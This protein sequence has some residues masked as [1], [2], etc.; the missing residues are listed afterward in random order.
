MTD[1]RLAQSLVHE[2]RATHPPTEHRVA[3]HARLEARGVELVGIGRGAREPAG[4]SG[5]RRRVAHSVGGRDR[6]G[7]AYVVA[8]ATQHRP[9]A[10]SGRGPRRIDGYSRDRCPEGH[11][12]V[13]SLVEWGDLRQCR[14]TR[15]DREE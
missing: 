8:G 5:D 6:L 10:I 1:P 9:Q 4:E 2:R 7:I 14:V 3:P 11:G 12:D 13:E 15:H